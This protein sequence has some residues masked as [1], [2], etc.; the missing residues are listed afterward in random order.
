M[1]TAPI[2]TSF[3]GGELSP[4]LGGRVDVAKYAI[5]C[6]VMEGFIPLT[7]GPA[8][9]RPGFVLVEE[10]KTST[11]RTWFVRFEFSEDDAYMIEVGHLYMRFYALR[12]Q[13]LLAGVP[14]EIVTPFV[15]TDLTNTDGTFALRSVGTGDEI[16]LVHPKYPPQLL[17]RHSATNWT[18]APVAFAPPPF[19]VQNITT[20]TVYASAATGVVLLVASA[21]VWT[22]ADV[23]TYFYLGERDVRDVQLWEVGKAITAG[24]IR[25][26]NGINYQA[27]STATTGAVKPT[28]TSGATYDGDGAVQWQFLDPG[29]GWVKITAFTDSTHVA[30][31]VV[32]E[33]PTGAV[34]S[35]QASTRWAHQAWN[36]TDGYPTCVAFFRERLVF[37]RNSTLWFSVSGD[38]PNFAYEVAATVTADSGFDRTLASALANQ[39]RW[40]SPGDVLLVGT[41]GDEW[42]I[43]ESSESEAFG[44]TNCRTK[45][46]SG[47][48][49]NRVDPRIVGTDT[50][51][52]QKS[53]RKARAM[54]FR[55][56]TN[57]FSSPDI[58]VYAEHVT[59]RGVIAMAFQQEPWGVL[60]MVRADGVLIGLT[61]N[62][63]QDAV[64]WHRHPLSGG[65]VECI[66]CIPS[67]DGTHDDLWAIVRYTIN[68]ATKRYVAYLA[69]PASVEMAQEDWIYS[70]MALTYRGAPATTITGLAPLEGKLVWVL[71]DGARHPDRTVSGGQIELQVPGSVVTVGLP[72]PAT[73][74]PMDIEGGSGNGTSQGKTKRAHLVTF[75][76][77]ET[78]GGRAG[79]ST[80]NLEEMRY[81]LPEVPMGSAPPAFTG[82]VDVEWRGDYD[83]T[84]PIVV[85]K[86]RPQ[87]ITVLSVMPQYSV[88]EG[89]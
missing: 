65:I 33:I 84:L 87:P 56:E 27:L 16:Y 59:K 39:I 29:Y 12:G 49:S 19:G 4:L 30:G 11:A 70:D 28:H 24:A 75:R 79:P 48:G 44:P 77:L 15:G 54:A 66:E 14:Y 26:S 89:R 51:F 34:G 1:K 3:N 71:V 46:Q 85:V 88:S 7:Q 31:T 61:L 21:A 45:A 18:I 53:G 40:M 43:V 68:G 22:A 73:L 67:P 63:E 50:V 41:S 60:W 52:M 78:S 13:V 57:G 64:A 81:R 10:V 86:D 76:V 32:S 23:N 37:A 35:G 36:A 5:G 8:T 9:T 82:D 83:K 38:F 20:T 42:A 25:R 6:K 72:S 17:S 74:Q 69:D 58:T 2:I 47:Y 62:R 55:F 80:D